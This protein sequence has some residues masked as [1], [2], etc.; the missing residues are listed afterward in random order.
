MKTISDTERRVVASYIRRLCRAPYVTDSTMR[1]DL[2]DYITENELVRT[3]SFPGYFV[4][5]TDKGRNFL[6]TEDE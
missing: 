1:R 5:I 3:V 4:Q 6:E 2:L